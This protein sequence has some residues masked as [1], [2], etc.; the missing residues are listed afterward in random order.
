MNSTANSES[1]TPLVQVAMRSVS[2]KVEE[3][4]VKV[5]IL[6]DHGAELLLLHLLFQ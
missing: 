6:A 4:M 3:E 1:H 5:L 2:A